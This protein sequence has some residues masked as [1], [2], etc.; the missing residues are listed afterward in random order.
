MCLLVLF[1][2]VVDDAPLVLGANR[3]E[4]YA[5]GGLPP[6]VLEGPV[7]TAAGIDPTAGG[8]WLGIN[9]YGVMV[10]VTNRPLSQLPQRPRSRGLLTRDLLTQPNAASAAQYAV[11]E[12]ETK[13]YAG[14]NYLIAD[15]HSSIVIEAGD[16]LRVRPLPPGLHLL[17]NGDVND[18][19]DAR[20]NYS[21]DVLQRTNYRQAEDCVTALR[22]LLG[23]REPE[24][25][26]VCLHLGE[27]G[28]V[29]SSILLVRRSLGDSEYW[30]AQ[31]PPDQ[32]PYT[33][34]SDLLK[35]LNGDVNHHP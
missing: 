20:L 12:L 15:A 9:Q 1:Y 33:D 2:R 23:L 29:S 21:L 17:S 22:H 4:Y 5:R 27:R 3:E 34:Y 26:P 32:T 18:P 6:R 11:R 31:G 30:H 24:R 25:P 8:T 14:C 13:H 16:W 28:T 19:N 10:A 35:R 7:R